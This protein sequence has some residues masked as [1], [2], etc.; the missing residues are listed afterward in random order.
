MKR[1]LCSGAGGSAAGTAGAAGFAA[2]FTGA[3]GACAAGFTGSA[4]F[5]GAT[6]R[7]A[8]GGCAVCCV[9]A[10]STSP[11]FEIF[12]RSI[13]GLN[14]SCAGAALREVDPPPPDCPAK[15]ARTFAASS[16]SI[17]LEW[18]F[19]SVT[20]TFG[21]TSRIALLFTS[22]SR[23]KSLIRIFIRPQFPPSVP[24]AAKP[25]SQPHGFRFQVPALVATL[26]LPGSP[27]LSLRRRVG[28]PYCFSGGISSSAG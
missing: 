25:S 12:E 3:A 15:Y 14:S 26:T 19:F 16:S 23:A 6:G 13:F 4:G 28:F 27:T 22:S 8:A 18:V 21:R 20:P 1:G 7:A 11:G 10:F 24:P 5:G 2:G 17:E 9:M